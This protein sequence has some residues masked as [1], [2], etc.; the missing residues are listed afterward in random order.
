MPNSFEV[1]IE[2][3][4]SSLIR[5]LDQVRE[6]PRPLMHAAGT[7]TINLIKLGFRKGVD[8]YGRP[9]SAVLR[10]GQPLR[11]TGRLMNSFA[12]S[13]LSEHSVR[14]GTN[15]CYAP[16]HQF[17]ATVHAS[18][19]PLGKGK[20]HIS[21]CGYVTTGAEYLFIR[22]KGGSA[23]MVQ[24]VEIPRRM[25]MP[26]KGRGWPAAWTKRIQSAV[27]ARWRQI[28]N[29]HGPPAPTVTKM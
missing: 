7:K 20:G 18:G 5:Q 13:V 3:N 25:F 22:G 10:G 2:E 21:L 27:N 1:L 28:I 8:P 9:W 4:L 24:S 11:D 16:V 6:H 12:L 26:T 15:V 29:T 17:G 14:V 19:S 23:A